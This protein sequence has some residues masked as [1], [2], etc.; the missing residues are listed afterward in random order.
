MMDFAGSQFVHYSR[1]KAPKEFFLLPLC[2]LWFHIRL[3]RLASFVHKEPWQPNSKIAVSWRIRCTTWVTARALQ[4]SAAFFVPCFPLTAAQ[5][6]SQGVLSVVILNV[7][8]KAMILLR[9]DA[10]RVWC[11]THAWRVCLHGELAL[12][13]PTYTGNVHYFF[14]HLLIS[15]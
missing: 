9:Q 12:L 7:I 2:F 4:L 1:E 10:L 11:Y 15:S 13:L 5:L 8:G 14:F 3:L 6:V